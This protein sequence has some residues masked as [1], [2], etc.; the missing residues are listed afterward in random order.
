M[1]VNKTIRRQS[2]DLNTQKLG[3]SLRTLPA[4][5]AARLSTWPPVFPPARLPPRPPARLSTCPLVRLP[6]PPVRLPAPVRLSACLPVSACP[7]DISI[8]YE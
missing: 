4:C 7:P 1:I 6:G 3:N 2:V 8:G 5:P